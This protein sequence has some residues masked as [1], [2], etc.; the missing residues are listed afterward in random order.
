MTGAVAAVAPAS[1]PLLFTEE[2]NFGLNLLGP[3]KIPGTIVSNLAPNGYSNLDD[4]DYF[5]HKDFGY[6]YSAK[7]RQYLNRGGANYNE[8]VTKLL[9]GLVWR[10][11]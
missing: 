8:E 3:L 1:P 9:Q 10:A 2:H 7:I 4:L 6:F 11:S 5:G